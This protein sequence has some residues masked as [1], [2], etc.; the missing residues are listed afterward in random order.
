MVVER[1]K[2]FYVMYK[3]K[4]VAFEQP[5]HSWLPLCKQLMSITLDIQGRES[6][7]EFISFVVHCM[8]LMAKVMPHKGAP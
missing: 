4:K 2:Y 5:L 1:N 7:Y 8:V 3:E 6:F